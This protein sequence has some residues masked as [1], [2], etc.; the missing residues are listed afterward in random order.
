MKIHDILHTTHPVFSFEFFPPKTE[1]QQRQLLETIRRLGPL[2]PAYVSV[3]YGAG[4]STRA[5]TIDTV[6]RIKDEFGIEADR[7]SVV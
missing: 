7:K 1:D 4:G 5:L 2:S 3:T 6:N